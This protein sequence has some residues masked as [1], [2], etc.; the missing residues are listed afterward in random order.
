MSYRRGGFSVNR[1]R[2][3]ARNVMYRA[4]RVRSPGAWLA[5]VGCIV[6]L[7]CVVCVGAAFVAVYLY[8]QPVQSS[9]SL[10]LLAAL[11][12]AWPAGW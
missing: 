2:N 7:L 6:L 3:Q 8:L 11:G 12:L 1:L 5:G 9:L 4:R 10:P